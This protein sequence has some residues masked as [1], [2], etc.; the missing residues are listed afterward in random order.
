MR[1]AEADLCCGGGYCL[2]A[3]AVG[4]MARGEASELP[5]G[6]GKKHQVSFLSYTEESSP[7]CCESPSWAMC[8]GLAKG[9]LLEDRAPGSRC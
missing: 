5:R 4:T 7:L 1:P 3:A 8:Q 9:A 6:Q 2:S